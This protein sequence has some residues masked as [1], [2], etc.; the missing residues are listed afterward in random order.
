[1]KYMLD[2]QDLFQENRFTSLKYKL[3][4][5]FGTKQHF[6]ELIGTI[7]VTIDR[8]EYLSYTVINDETLILMI[9][10]DELRKTKLDP[11]D[12]ASLNTKLEEVFANKRKIMN[13][14]LP[15]KDNHVFPDVIDFLSIFF[16]TL[17]HYLDISIE[18]KFMNDP[19]IIDTVNQ[20][21][22]KWKDF[23]PLEI[24]LIN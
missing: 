2:N 24:S 8:F 10:M 3:Q 22:V 20:H 17:N 5:L 12:P 4:V 13:T 6:P 7:E 18:T 23:I 14:N 1:M 16:T 11:N 21:Y 15:E 9:P 19:V